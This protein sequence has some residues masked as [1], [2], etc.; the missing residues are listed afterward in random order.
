MI[1]NI[2]NNVKCV[3]LWDSEGCIACALLTYKAYLCILMLRP[4]LYYLYYALK[5]KEQSTHFLSV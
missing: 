4:N 2:K 1:A 5:V 3:A